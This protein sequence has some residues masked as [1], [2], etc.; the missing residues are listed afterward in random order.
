MEDIDKE[1]KKKLFLRLRKISEFCIMLSLSMMLL[2]FLSIF[3]FI[4]IHGNNV[5]EK[6]YL[7][8]FI[9]SPILKVFTIN[10]SLNILAGIFTFGYIFFIVTLVFYTF[11]QEK[12]N[13]DFLILCGTL[14]ADLVISFYVFVLQNDKP[15]FFMEC[16]MFIL[17][18]FNIYVLLKGLIYIITKF[19]RADSKTKISILV[20]IFT[21]VI[22]YILGK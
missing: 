3:I 6:S 13:I 19:V 18:I 2:A 4:F 8:Q 5:E 22:G 12:I 17:A 21:A 11:I 10:D 20:P 14:I 7:N 1:N 9:I 16:F 15:L